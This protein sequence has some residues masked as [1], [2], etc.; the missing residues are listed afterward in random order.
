MVGSSGFARRADTT[1]E[2]WNEPN[3]ASIPAAEYGGFVNE[4]ANTIHS[5]SLGGNPEILSGGLLVWGNS[6]HNETGAVTYLG[7]LRY[8]EEAYGHF[9]S[10]PYVSG[11]AIHPYELDPE[12]FHQP[13]YTAVQAFEYAVSGFRGKLNLLATFNE[14]PQKQLSITEFGWPAEG[15]QWNVGESQ[16][17]A[18]LGEA[19][20]YARGNAGSLQLTNLD[21]YN[22]RDASGE[23][24]EWARYCGLRANDGHFRT[25]WT[26]FQAKALVRQWIPQAPTI[27]TSTATQITDSQATLN[28][29]V[30]PRGLPTHYRF[31]YGATPSYGNSVPQA[32]ADAGSGESAIQVSAT[33]EGLRPG[34]TY[35]YRLVAINAVNASYGPDRTFTTVSDARVATVVIPGEGVISDWR[36]SD[37]NLYETV[38]VNGKWTTFSP[39]WE[40]NPAGVAVTGDPSATISSANGLTIVWRGSDGNLYETLA[41]NG[42]WQTFSPTWGAIFGTVSL[43]AESSR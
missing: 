43:A 1:W 34:T 38:A 3:N 37:G 36:G 6:P 22:F 26:E 32:G 13:G 33:L 40:G 35:H 29:S 4:I 28:G 42:K 2:I 11:V 25:A 8:L 27:E 39:T 41:V 18:L 10:N 7:A 31:E 16:Q 5:A 24:N 17:A 19:I 9:G 21:W 14:T 15:G 23:I 20:D 12:S 30:N